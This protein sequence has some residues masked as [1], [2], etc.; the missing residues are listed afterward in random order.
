MYIITLINLIVYQFNYMIICQKFEQNTFD[1]DIHSKL[2]IFWMNFSNPYLFYTMDKDNEE[3][4]P[5]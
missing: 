2:I 1:A 5:Y 4:L 3:I